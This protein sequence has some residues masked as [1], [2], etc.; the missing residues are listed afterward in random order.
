MPNT[1]PESLETLLQRALELGLI[2]HYERRGDRIY[3]EAASLQVELTATQARRWIEAMLENF[4]R[5]QG[6][7]ID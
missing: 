3:L 1:Y 2:D 4:R 7:D 6:K 5:I